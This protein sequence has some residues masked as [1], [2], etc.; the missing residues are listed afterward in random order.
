MGL[1]R[2]SEL[3]KPCCRISLK[4]QTRKMGAEVTEALS[5]SLDLLVSKTR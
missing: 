5:L 3:S 2:Q 1:N 4:L